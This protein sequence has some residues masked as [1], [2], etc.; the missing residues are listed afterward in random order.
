MVQDH[1][2][3]S[4]HES[5]QPAELV[6]GVFD[7]LQP[8][9]GRSTPN[10]LHQSG[11]VAG[12]VADRGAIVGLLLTLLADEL[13]ERVRKATQYRIGDPRRGRIDARPALVI[14]PS[15]PFFLLKGTQPADDAGHGKQELA[16]VGHRAGAF[17]I[18][19]PDRDVIQ[20]QWPVQ[21]GPVDALFLVFIDHQLAAAWQRQ[22][23]MRNRPAVD[24]DGARYLGPQLA[25]LLAPVHGRSSAGPERS[26]KLSLG[27]GIVDQ[28]RQ[29]LLR[30]QA[31][32]RGQNRVHTS[33]ALYRW[34]LALQQ[35][36]EWSD[37][38]SAAGALARLATDSTP[39]TIAQLSHPKETDSHL[40]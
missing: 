27:S 5:E 39:A 22:R 3:R 29:P 26:G 38:S 21:F 18:R 28:T 25:A 6:L 8:Y 19:Q 13:E 40:I 32:V 11:V 30:T 36:C 17:R 16:P 4:N 15:C 37:Q 1:Q 12:D 20:R 2:T 35:S 9:L 7:N 10:H 33:P 24:A 23:H 31:S 34:Q 14:H